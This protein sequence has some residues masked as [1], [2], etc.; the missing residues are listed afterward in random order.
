MLIGMRFGFR[1]SVHHSY[2]RISSEMLS[3]LEAVR[4][5]PRL[6]RNEI[7]RPSSVLS[8]RRSFD[9]LV[10]DPRVQRKKDVLPEEEEPAELTTSGSLA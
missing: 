4:L 9:R 7:A 8:P 1:A 10:I 5:T 3:A 6:A 2:Y